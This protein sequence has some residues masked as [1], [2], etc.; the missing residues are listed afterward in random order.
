MELKSAGGRIFW[1]AA[2]SSVVSSHQLYNA[3]GTL[4]R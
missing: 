2:I 4:P 3:Q 1:L